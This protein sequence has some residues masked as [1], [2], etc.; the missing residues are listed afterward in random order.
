MRNSWLDIP[1]ADYEAHMALPT[2]G[3][4]QLLSELFADALKRHRP[5]SVAILGC[6]G[7]NGLERVAEFGVERV[8]G[9]DINPSYIEST[10]TRFRGRLRELELYVGD[11]QV[12]D[13]SFAPVELVFAGLLFE[14]V[15]P[16]RTLSKIQA[17]LEPG[18]VLVCVLQL[19][20]AT[21]T[22]TPSPYDSLQSLSSLMHLISPTQLE[23]FG[24]ELGF[25]AEATQ[26]RESIGGKQFS[27]HDFR[28]TG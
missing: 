9:V 24:A 7:G 15:D 18:G 8:I 2:V 1:L 17:M 27:V 20:S 26:I 13:F 22:V 25:I 14:Y 12:D 11:V 23:H 10:A 6:A 4:S 3:Q 21:A 19:P 28:V 16:L 5:R